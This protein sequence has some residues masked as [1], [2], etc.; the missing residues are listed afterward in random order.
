MS[1]IRIAFGDAEVAACQQTASLSD[2]LVKRCSTHAADVVAAIDNNALSRH[3]G[4]FTAAE[5]RDR[6]RDVIGMANAS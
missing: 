3:E 5:P 6:T 2:L 4:C 1:L